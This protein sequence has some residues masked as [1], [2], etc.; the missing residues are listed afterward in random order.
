[1]TKNGLLPSMF[2]VLFIVLLKTLLAVFSSRFCT[3][4]TIVAVLL[5]TISS[6]TG[7]AFKKRNI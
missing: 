4:S 1:M 2:R 5:V 7:V 3:T 6:E